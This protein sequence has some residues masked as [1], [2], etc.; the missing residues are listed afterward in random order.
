MVYCEEDKE[1][2]MKKWIAGLLSLALV[3]TLF[4]PTMI[5]AFAEGGSTQSGKV[6]YPAVYLRQAPWGEI[7]DLIY[8]GTTVEILGSQKDSEGNIWY[9]VK[10][11]A[12]RGFM[13]GEY[14]DLE[15]SDTTIK[16]EELKGS[17]KVTWD[18]ARVRETPWGTILGQLNRGE[19]AEVTGK[20]KDSD[21]ALWYRVKFNGKTG[22]VHEENVSYSSP[23]APAPEP[24]K[25]TVPA[26]KDEAV[27]GTIKVTWDFARVRETPWGTILGQL[28]YGQSAEVTAKAKD[29]D[30]ATWY[31]IKYNGK[32][33]YVHEDNVAFT[34]ASSGSNESGPTL[35]E[36]ALKGTIKVTWD[37]ARVR[38]TPWG[39]IL[40]QLD[41][42]QTAEVSA[43]TL[44]SDGASWYKIKFSGKDGYVHEDNVSF[45]PSTSGSTE[46]TPNKDEEL[47]GTI[48]VTWDFAR[49]RKTP[50]GTILGQLNR[51]DTAQ[52][53]GKTKDSDGATWYK[54]KY[55]GQDGYVHEDN[56]SFTPSSGS[57]TP[58]P[59]GKDEETKGTIK[60]TWDFARV[61]ET[62]W[63]TI[64]GQLNKGQSAD[65]TALTKDSDGA[66]WYKI[67]YNAKD[68][69]VHEENVSFAA[70]PSTPGNPE[71]EKPTAKN[72]LRVNYS[73]LNV[74][75]KPSTSAKIVTTIADLTT[76]EYFE[77][78][79]DE[80]GDLWYRIEKGWVHGDY[81][82]I[83]PQK[84]TDIHLILSTLEYTGNPIEVSAQ[85][86]GTSRAL[87]KIS[88]KQGT[89]YKVLSDFSSNRSAR[90]TPTSEGSY[91]LMV[92]AKDVQA[93]GVEKTFEQSFT[94]KKDLYPHTITYVEYG[95]LETFARSQVGR[96]VKW[97]DGYWVDATYEEILREMDPQNALTFTL[98]EA[99][100]SSERR[101]RITDTVNVRTGPGR[102]NP[103][104]GLAYSGEKYLLL[105]TATVNG[106]T[107]N[108]I[109]FEG[110]IGWFHSGYAMDVTAAKPGMEV[111]VGDFVTIIANGT[112]LRRTPS[113][114]AETLS[115]L[116]SHSS[117]MV[118]ERSGTWMKVQHKGTEG[119]I[120][121]SEAYGTDQVNTDM[122][123]FLDLRGGTGITPEELN[124]VLQGKGILHGQGE[125]FVEASRL[126]D[127][128]EI[129]LVS[130]AL[131]ET[132]NG[133]SELATGQRVNGTM[134]YNMYGIGAYDQDPVTLGAQTAYE[135]G[136]T[137]PEKAIIDG[138]RWIA[139]AYVH[140]SDG[141]YTL[142]KM[143]YNY[144]DP[145]YQYA[146]DIAW[147]RAQTD[148]IR[149]LY[150]MVQ[151]YHLRFEIPIYVEQ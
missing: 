149:N 32:D 29:S 70:S 10:V 145:H 81:V 39:T 128:N 129:Y 64:L 85:A 125:A 21:G 25:P 55:S 82:D 76:H 30:G 113:P 123:Q 115:Y 136:W 13:Y 104:I 131:L 5:P 19:S 90:F 150:G 75:E 3:L 12:K 47:K 68:G 144:M 61:R 98:P 59:P 114:S 99:H 31:K 56:V 111:K 1:V 141:Q 151:G 138:A 78:T 62:P 46:T 94:L 43:K 140:N 109:E 148:Q 71:P 11:N 15:K 79:R 17:V 84:V 49:V 2:Y 42:G 74:R 24:E 137:T 16:V 72:T 89:A 51:G 63:G 127:I 134:V 54:I 34:L 80:R 66:T 60:V 50:W 18:F 4:T 101:L 88:L 96:A 120:Q 143:R 7:I 38:S 57:T 122:F 87:Y 22:Y 26:V 52:V 132:G 135:N 105:D 117:Y 103:A 92:E 77:E 6:N 118:L 73:T 35:K 41:R 23:A 44:D 130:H 146:T 45:T 108:K 100:P 142:Y 48:K 107:W 36:E 91:T 40:G 67:K 95:S 58:T 86:I 106:E 126:H 116:A 8:E 147:A 112:A 102:D 14:I 124:K 28:N 20:T 97:K 33:G 9:E 110:Q 83:G 37:F 93:S 27:K 65:V 139:S 53:S 69:Y 121:N 119:W 133:S